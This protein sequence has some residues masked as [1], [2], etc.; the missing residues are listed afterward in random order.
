MVI[1]TPRVTLRELR[2]QDA[3]SILD[4]KREPDW[5]DGYPHDGTAPAARGCVQRPDD[6]YIPGFG[7]YYIVRSSD[8]LV[9]GDIGFHTPPR[10]GVV[11]IGY[12]LAEAARGQGYATEAL[13]ALTAWALAQPGVRRVTADTTPDNAPSQRV[14]ERS[15]FRC[16]RADESLLHYVADPA[17]WRQV[18]RD[19]RD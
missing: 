18:H 15:G 12:G 13:T 19:R 10:D 3:Q 2:P 16:L 9:V 5:C 11:E 6:Q 8:A 14:L 7:M 17:T 1:R 4:G